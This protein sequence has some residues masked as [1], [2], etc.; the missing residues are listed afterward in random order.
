MCSDIRLSGQHTLAGGKRIDRD[1]DALFSQDAGQEQKPE[2][3]DGRRKLR[4]DI[5][6]ARAFGGRHGRLDVNRLCGI[7][8]EREKPLPERFAENGERRRARVGAAEQRALETTAP[9]TETRRLRP[10]P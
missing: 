1:V 3:L 5:E 4:L 10:S 8:T 2:R 9:Q 7:D 6:L